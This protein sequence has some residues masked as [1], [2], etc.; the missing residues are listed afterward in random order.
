MFRWETLASLKFAWASGSFL[1]SIGQV[2]ILHLVFEHFKEPLNWL[3]V[4]LIVL[5]N[6]LLWGWKYLRSSREPENG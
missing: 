1:G 5:L 2:W 6:D 3:W 4:L